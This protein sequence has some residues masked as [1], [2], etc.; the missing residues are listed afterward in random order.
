M[1]FLLL[2]VI[3]YTDRRK[4]GEFLGCGAIQINPKAILYLIDI[5]NEAGKIEGNLP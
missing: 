3:P 2:F 5:Y 4:L 1:V